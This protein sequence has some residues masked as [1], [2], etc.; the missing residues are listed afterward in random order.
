[1]LVY[2]TTASMFTPTFDDGQGGLTTKW[3]ALHAATTDLIQAY[4]QELFLLGA[5]L[6][7]QA[8]TTDVSSIDACAVATPPDA[9]VTYPPTEVLSQ[10]PIADPFSIMEGGATPTAAATRAADV[11]LSDV[12]GLW[13][14]SSYLIVVTDDAPNCRPDLVEAAT[15]CG[16]D[17]V[18]SQAA[19]AEALETYDD[20]APEATVNANAHATFVIGLD[21]LDFDPMSGIPCTS[22]AD[23]PD[24][25]AC[26]S[27]AQGDTNCPVDG[28]CALLPGTAKN[29][30]PS[31]ALADFA[32]GGNHPN[33]PVTGYHDVTDAIELQAAFDDIVD[34]IPLCTWAIPTSD[35]PGLHDEALT[36]LFGDQGGYGHCLDADDVPLPNCTPGFLDEA[37]CETQDGVVRIESSPDYLR[38]Y[39][40]N[41]ACEAYKIHGA[42]EFLFNGCEDRP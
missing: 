35:Y 11:Y 21:I 30:N 13:H 20:T 4:P 27:A 16:D 5:Q 42:I 8:G 41:D 38:I 23:C 2:D 29:V 36:V 24:R 33:P 22:D 17:P 39:A 7:P 32:A 12:F 3:S 18:C 31:Q 9:P 14:M 6:V 26:C 25:T 37:A 15:Q 34:A 1:M 40:C 28:T 10:I 19:L